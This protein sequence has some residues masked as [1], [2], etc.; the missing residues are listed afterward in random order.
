MEK[1][2]DVLTEVNNFMK[3]KSSYQG[4]VY[5]LSSHNCRTFSHTIADF[6]GVGDRY[7][8]IIRKNGFM[9][10]EAPSENLCQM[11]FQN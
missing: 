4:T 9:W 10:A 8:E 3:L 1:G 5:S 11:S 6:L 7:L 2:L